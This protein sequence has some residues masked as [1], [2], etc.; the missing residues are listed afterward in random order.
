MTYNPITTM[1][2]VWTVIRKR[3]MQLNYR[4]LATQL[5]L[6]YNPVIV[7]FVVNFFT[8]DL[9]I[10]TSKYRKIQYTFPLTTLYYQPNAVKFTCM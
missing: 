5:P 10:T 8:Y 7:N 3:R 1:A 4:S 6:T 9:H 2:F